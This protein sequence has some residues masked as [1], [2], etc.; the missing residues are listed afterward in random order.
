[1]LG[2]YM[3]A[4]VPQ[5][6]LGLHQTRNRKQL[7]CSVWFT[8]NFTVDNGVLPCPRDSWEP[9]AKSSYMHFTRAL[10][11]GVIM[12]LSERTKAGTARYSASFFI[13][14][15]EKLCYQLSIYCSRVALIIVPYI[16]SGSC[17]AYR[18]ST[19]G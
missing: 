6:L 10:V 19:N 17:L 14:Y 3:I 9:S 18:Q 13:N 4:M 5:L 1:M 16:P 12:K 11:G 7:Y 8:G 15:R 2:R